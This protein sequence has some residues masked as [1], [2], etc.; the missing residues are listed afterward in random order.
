V[1]LHLALRL[2]PESGP[3]VEQA[4][5]GLLKQG[6]SPLLGEALATG[7]H[8]RELD[9]IE[10]VLK[11]PTGKDNPIDKS[12]IF[13]ILAGCVMAEH[14]PGRVARLIDIVASL[15]P[16]SPRALVLLEAMVPKV[17]S[18][19]APP[20]KLIYLDH[21]PAALAQLQTGADAKA[22]QLADKLDKVLAWPGKPGVPPPPKIIP[23]T[24]PQQALFEKGKNLYANICAACHQPSGAGLDGLAPPL[25][26]SEWALG[27]PD[28]PIRIVL[29]GVSGPLPVAGRTWQLEM[30]PLAVLGD[31][32]IAG[33]LTY[34]RREWEHNSSPVL[35][36][37]VAK[38]RAAVKDRTTPWTAEE[39][40]PADKKAAPTK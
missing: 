23:L 26:D 38:I 9:F 33:V 25:L 30:P 35:P 19:S 21:Q 20:P 28:R 24:P 31:E 2:G 37:D 12:G 7:L 11:Q 22:K 3:E 4:L 14:K 32:D 40:K 5:I 39:L 36:A 18:K 15:P 6:G 27:A 13:P 16:N 17:K 10:T 34:I 8:G 29:Q 1:R